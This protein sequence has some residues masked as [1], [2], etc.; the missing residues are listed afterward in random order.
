MPPE[1]PSRAMA[2]LIARMQNASVCALLIPAWY[3]AS[4]MPQMYVEPEPSI[5]HGTS[6][7]VPPMGSA[8]TCC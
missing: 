6:I 7:N 4:I 5:A 2:R 8:N 1:E 3:S